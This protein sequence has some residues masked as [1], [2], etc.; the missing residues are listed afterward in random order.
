MANVEFD[1]VTS[2]YCSVVMASVKILWTLV[3]LGGANV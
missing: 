3:A 2:A 1:G